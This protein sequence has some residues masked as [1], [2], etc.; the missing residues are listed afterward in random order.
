VAS[1]FEDGLFFNLGSMGDESPG[2]LKGLS[3]TCI[4]LRMFLTVLSMTPQNY[5]IPMYVLQESSYLPIFYSAIVFQ[6]IESR[7]LKGT[8]CISSSKSILFPTNSFT[9][10]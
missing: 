3:S 1:V 4:L 7:G 2:F 9:T 6:A 5:S 10:F 8:V